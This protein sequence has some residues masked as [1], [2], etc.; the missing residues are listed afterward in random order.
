MSYIKKKFSTFFLKTTTLACFKYF[1]S[2]VVK[3]KV[4][5]MAYTTIWENMYGSTTVCEIFSN[6]P[7][8]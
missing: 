4:A 3:K 1:Q 6:L 2:I 7:P 5:K 8:F